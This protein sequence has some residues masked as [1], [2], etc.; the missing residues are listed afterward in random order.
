MVWGVARLPGAGDTV[1]ADRF[2]RHG[3][4]KGANQAVAAARA[5]ATVAFIGAVG[6]DD[7][8]TRAVAEL[9][10]EGV[11]TSCIARIDDA[12]T[13]MA[14]I[15]VDSRGE[16]QI[17]VSPGANARL[18]P[19][20]VE[21]AMGWIE[22]PA[23]GVCLLDFEIPDE[24]LLAAI[25]SARGAGVRTIIVNPAP[26]R[27]LPDRLLECSPLLTP[28]EGEAM[29]LS[30]ESDPELAARTL[31]GRTSAQV[32]VTLGE[33]G[34]ALVDGERIARF[35]APAVR[36]LDTTGAGDV[37]NGVLAASLAGGME[38]AGAVARAVAA[39]AS[40]VQQ[41]GARGGFEIQ[42]ETKEAR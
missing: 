23:D 40:S 7:F 35:D 28:N 34:A 41:H 33:R 22:P 29:K 30:G 13:G 16:N 21:R 24:A 3:G 20:L 31:A 12:P 8:G 26:A 1:I 4:G 36:A 37:F 39:A 38:L 9:G 19:A 15:V 42:A 25:R 18:D 32:I 27:E 6:S 17:A 2:E 14:S 11:D 5:G 10:R